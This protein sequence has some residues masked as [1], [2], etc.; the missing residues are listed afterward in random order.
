[1]YMCDYFMTMYFYLSILYH[2]DDYII[3][4]IIHPKQLSELEAHLGHTWCQCILTRK[5]TQIRDCGR[6]LGSAGPGAVTITTVKRA[7]VKPS[8][9]HDT[10]FLKSAPASWVPRLNGYLAL[11]GKI[12]FQNC[13][14]AC[15]LELLARKKT[16]YSLV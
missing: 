1:M 15:F 8:A 9:S 6:P 4:I 16:R 2:I 3:T 14:R 13:M 11:Q 10:S 5:P 12:H 7:T